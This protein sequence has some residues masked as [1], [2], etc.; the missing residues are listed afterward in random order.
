MIG[1]SRDNGR[2]QGEGH[3]R[4]GNHYRDV[5]PN[6]ELAVT[7]GGGYLDASTF[8][9]LLEGFPKNDALARRQGAWG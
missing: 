2:P 7:V 4:L 8:E 9:A 3:A 5:T 6:I 1:V